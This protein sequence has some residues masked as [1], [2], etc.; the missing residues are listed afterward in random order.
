[1]SDKGAEL[2]RSHDRFREW[3]EATNLLGRIRATEALDTLINCLEC[4]DG[5]FG[6]SLGRFPAALGVVNFGEAAIP[7]LSAALKRKEP[8][9]RYK[10]AEVLYAMGGDRAKHLVKK[11]VPNE[12]VRW[13]ADAMKNMLRTW[14]VQRE[15]PK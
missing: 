13:I 8:M 2:V 9:T 7:K 1:V 4:N 12:R 15:A 5:R 6:L 14:N 3:S 11:A 10:A